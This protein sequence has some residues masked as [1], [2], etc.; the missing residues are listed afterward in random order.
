WKPGEILAASALAS[1]V[2]TAAALTKLT[3]LGCWLTKQTNATSIA[4]GGLLTD[5]DS[6][7]HV[8]LQNRAAIDSI[9]MRTWVGRFE[10]ICCMNLPD[11]SESIHHQLKQLKD[12]T[13]QLQHNNDPDW[14]KQLLCGW[15]IRDWLQELVMKIGIILLIIVIL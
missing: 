7:R 14:L 12:L 5:V 8:T 10:G 4:L 13:K 2:A 15:G 9:S 1:G 3:N 11:H 6:V